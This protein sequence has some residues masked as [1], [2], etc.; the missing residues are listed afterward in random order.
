MR[1]SFL[2]ALLLIVD[3]ESGFKMEEREALSRS[4]AA[5]LL[6]PEALPIP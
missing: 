4:F 3:R 6:M 1:Y 5:R 2:P